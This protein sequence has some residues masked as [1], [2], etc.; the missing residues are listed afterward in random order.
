VATRRGTV[1]GGAG[2]LF[3]A[4]LVVAATAQA[5]GE[6]TRSSLE[7]LSP[8]VERQI[9]AGAI[10]GAV[11]LVGQRAEIVYRRAAGNRELFPREVAM[12]E[13][14]IFDLASLTK[15]IA[16]GTAVLQLVESHRLALDE[17]ASKYWPE[18]AANGKDGIT[19]RQLLT[20]TSGLRA[21]LDTRKPWSG[22]A[23]ALRRIADERPVRS[24]GASVIYSDINFQILGE[25]VR[26]ASGLPLDQYCDRFIFGP[27]GL[28]D[29]GFCP[30]ADLRP[31]IAPT[32]LRRGAATAGTV[33]DPTACRMGGVAGNAGLFGTADDLARF[34]RMMLGGGS[35]DGVRILAPETVAMMTAP[36][37]PAGRPGARGLAWDLDT[38]FGGTRGEPAGVYG[39]SGY[40]GTSLWVDPAS[41]TYVIILSNRVYPDGRGDAKPLRREVAAVVEAAL[42]NRQA[43]RITAGLSSPPL[44]LFP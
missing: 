1:R 36:Q 33:H 6:L 18:A 10:P 16:T 28:K 31:R 41:G 17:P 22:Y 43:K 40:T 5:Q 37:G 12:S 34:A 11:V 19:V 9:R 3:P 25:L 32:G 35:L 4:L 24:P 30:P 42:G 29:T 27:L 26:R 8:V 39:H 14:T 38:P 7:P 13:D 20:H 15:V 23:E 44:R 2:L 21:D